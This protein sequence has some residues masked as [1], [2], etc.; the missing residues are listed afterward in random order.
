MS[1]GQDESQQPLM[2]PAEQP[3]EAPIPVPAVAMGAP[4]MSR[5]A[6]IAAPSRPEIPILA[7]QHFAEP[8]PAD[9]RT[10]IMANTAHIHN[11]ILR[12][13]ARM[14][15]MA[16]NAMLES[17]PG[18]AEQESR[19]QQADTKLMQAEHQN[20]IVDLKAQHASELEKLREQARTALEGQ[21]E[22]GASALQG[23]K[24]EGA[25][26]LEATK[27]KAKPQPAVADLERQ[28]RQAFASGDMDLYK[29]SL[30]QI[31]DIQTAVHGG[32]AKPRQEVT[33]QTPDGKRVAGFKGPEGLMLENGQKAPEGTLLYQAATTGQT[34][35]ATIWDPQSGFPMTMQYNPDTGKYDQPVGISGTGPAAGRMAQAAAVAR[36]GE[37]L[38]NDLTKHK[39][40]LGSLQ[41]WVEK[42]GLN[43]PIADPDLAELQAELSS[44]AALQPAM[45]GFR[46]HSALEAFEKIIGGLQK[47]PDATIA[48]IRGILK[49]SGAL[50]PT[51]TPK[52][53]PTP[54]HGGSS[55]ADWKASQ[56]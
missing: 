13:L 19:M 15:G 14:S 36:G 56:K 51:A 49:T 3:R 6:P 10:A 18:I 26:T 22:A 47:D 32:G 50:L 53:P 8:H 48:S 21:K 24:Q 52:T 2:V 1:D 42:Y 29:S 23:E 55:F 31:K 7:P 33:L 16:G 46:S 5:I 4:D 12:T 40:Q 34:R 41:T 43:T 45:H 44:F 20:E 38:I 28:A 17:T 37:G 35:T 9:A 30:D 54:P 25:Q 39:D 11:P 27:E